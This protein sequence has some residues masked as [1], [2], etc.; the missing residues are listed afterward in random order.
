VR[1]IALVRIS[2][3]TSIPFVYWLAFDLIESFKVQPGLKFIIMKTSFLKRHFAFGLCSF[4]LLYFIL[5]F[6]ILIFFSHPATDDFA[7]ASSAIRF[8]VFGNVIQFYLNWFGRY[9][10][11]FIGGLQLFYLDFYFLY[12]SVT[13]VIFISFLLSIF[14]VLKLFYNGKLSFYFSLIFMILFFS[15]TPIISEVFYWQSGSFVYLLPNI[16]IFILI[17][18]LQQNKRINIYLCLLLVFMTVGSNEL[19][20][21][22]VDAVLLLYLAKQSE[23]HKRKTIL[24]IFLFAIICSSLVI[25]SPGNRVRA[26]AMALTG[27][28]NKHDLSLSL[29]LSMRAL[30]NCFTRWN[31]KFSLIFTSIL[32]FCKLRPSAEKRNIKLLLLQWSFFI[33]TI[34]SLYFSFY[35][36]AGISMEPRTES[37]ICLLFIISFSLLVVESLKGISFRGYNNSVFFITSVMLLLS[38]SQQYNLKYTRRDLTLGKAQ[39][40]N[41]QIINRLEYFKKNEGALEITLR[42]INDHDLPFAIHSSRTNFPNV[43]STERDSWL[44]WFMNKYKIQKVNLID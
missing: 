27:S 17:K 43:I 10:A 26:S 18:Q 8:G 4:G 37:V 14:G 35:W 1:W 33:A 36:S 7:T 24:I 22:I 12:Q 2:L 30:L 21:L 41:Q 28:A 32:L 31:A 23:R 44:G 39:G 5:P 38:F 25:L 29:S 15:Y 16:F 9:F 34:F 42:K 11:A 3:S 20:M 19:S 13:C 40:Y 6:F